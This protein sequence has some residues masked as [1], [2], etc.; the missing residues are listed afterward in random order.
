M[1]GQD[2]ADCS[3]GLFDTT[4]GK[5][6]SHVYLTI[7]PSLNRHQA[8]HGDKDGWGML[9]RGKDVPG[10]HAWPVSGGGGGAYRATRASGVRTSSVGKAVKKSRGFVVNK[11][12]A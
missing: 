6:E 2:D 10:L 4:A 12:P 7:Y 11:R 3:D 8:D 5:K 9:C 1:G